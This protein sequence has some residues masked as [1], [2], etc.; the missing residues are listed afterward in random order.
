MDCQ[1]LKFDKL[2]N[3]FQRVIGRLKSIKDEKTK[4]INLIN[5]LESKIDILEKCL[6]VF[7]VLSEMKKEEIKNKIEN[8][9]TKGLRTIFERSDYRFEIIMEQKRNVMTAK[10]LLYSEFQGKEYCSEIM[11]G[12]GGGLIDVISFI[13]QII[14]MISMRNTVNQIIIADEP[15]KHVSRDYLPN[16]AE[17]LKYLNEITYVQIIMVTHKSEFLDIADKKFEVNLNKKK[18]TVINQL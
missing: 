14:V 5:D 6:E 11:D 10:P 16:V 17:F 15:F 4:Y 7:Q 12:H 13:M 1:V 18:E 3:K 2:N 9:V 8:L